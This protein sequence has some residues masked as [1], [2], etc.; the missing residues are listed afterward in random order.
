M[1]G[2]VLIF[3]YLFWGDSVGG[4]SCLSGMLA[5]GGM[6]VVFLLG[7]LWVSRWKKRYADLERVYEASKT[8]AAA[9]EETFE[10]LKDR[11]AFLERRARAQ[12]E[13]S[14]ILKNEVADLSGR[15][16]DL[17]EKRRQE[18]VESTRSI[19]SL[20][21]KNKEMQQWLLEKMRQ[22]DRWER[23]QDEKYRED[24]RLFEE[25]K[26][27]HNVFFT[28]AIHE[29][30]TPLS[31]I[32]G[33]LG[34]VIRNQTLDVTAST[35]LLAAYR[36]TLAL[37]DLALQLHDARLGD[38]VTGHARVARYDLVEVTRQICDLFVDWI[39]L[40]KVDFRITAQTR[41]LWVWVDRRKLEFALR[42]LLSNALKNTFRYGRIVLDISVVRKADAE[43]GTDG[44]VLRRKVGQTSESDRQSWQGK[45]DGNSEPRSREVVFG[46][47]AT[48]ESWRTVLPDEVQSEGEAGERGFDRMVFP[49]SYC[50]LSIC[51]E[52]LGEKEN[53]RLGLKQIADM[54]RATR[55]EFTQ[56]GSPEAEGTCY[57]LGIPLGKRYLLERTVEFVEPDGDL[58]QLNEQQKEDIAELIRMI[59][60]QKVTGKKLLIID[61]SD[62]IRWFLNHLFCKE[63]EVLEARDGKEGIQTAREKLPDLIL[64]DV[65]MPLKDGFEVCREVK[66]DMLTRRIP[67]I[68]LTAKVGSED[69]IT[70]IECG[71]DDYITKPFDA[72]VLRSKV[73]SVLKRSEEV[74]SYFIN[75]SD[76]ISSPDFASDFGFSSEAVW[77]SRS[78]SDFQADPGCS[79][80]TSGVSGMAAKDAVPQVSSEEMPDAK[81]KDTLGSLFMESVLQTI[82]KHLDDA[83]F[84]AKV[85]ADALHMSLPTLYRKI[86]QYSDYSILELTRAV[87][88][89]KAAELICLQRYSIQ[90]VSERVGFNDPATFRKRFVEQYGVTPSQYAAQ[91]GR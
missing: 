1:L 23:E 22:T 41:V 78:C 15:Y 27:Q 24:V 83:G 33:S 34:E 7:R 32:L 89:K 86:K 70:G 14:R 87:R 4:G 36:N 80:K 56:V 46:E 66:A 48:G 18:A 71:A 90:E 62:Q 10:R 55:I 79:D 44:V 85:L 81:E 67:L 13:Q 39:A 35:C 52:G 30:R 45:G 12:E 9:A 5:G 69:V 50:R 58:V 19:Q 31:L 64:C 77:A 59:P 20:A 16:S 6:L 49:R 21:Q 84:E 68:L 91:M 60:Q 65:M 25:V 74:K 63:Y 61:D 38:D 88:L 2:N 29:M 42:T 72:E 75:S 57:T 73:R 3:I 51:D 37:Q 11:C 8:G 40:N 47:K 26:K 17:Q 53:T 76:A 43:E 82:E 54:A 28:E